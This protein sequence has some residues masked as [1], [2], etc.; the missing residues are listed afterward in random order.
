VGGGENATDFV[1]KLLH[2]S[3]ANPYSS[4]GSMRPY[5]QN[6]SSYMKMCKVEDSEISV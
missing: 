4:R 5:V 1:N 3:L 6:K 2:A